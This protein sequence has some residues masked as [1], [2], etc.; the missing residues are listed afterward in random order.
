[1]SGERVLRIASMRSP[2]NS[3]KPPFATMSSIPT[4]RRP[5]SGRIPTAPP[6]AGT[7]TSQHRHNLLVDHQRDEEMDLGRYLW[8]DAQFVRGPAL[9]SPE[10]RFRP[11]TLVTLSASNP[12][13][14]TLDGTDPVSRAEI[15]RRRSALQQ[16]PLLST[17]NARVFARARSAT[18][19]VAGH[20]LE[21][22]DHRHL[23][24]RHA[25]TDH[26]GDHVNPAP[27]GPGTCSSTRSSNTSK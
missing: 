9:S 24:R 4:P 8:V 6:T 21:R 23:C 14:Y 16:A 25:Q 11:G 15:R 7:W 19:H 5:T 22:P 10:A 13:Y 17:A 20:D 1:M 26:L 3:A 12:I 2:R 18:S 27:G